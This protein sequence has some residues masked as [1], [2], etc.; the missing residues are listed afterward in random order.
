MNGNVGSGRLKIRPRLILSIVL[1]ALICF[2]L[3]GWYVMSTALGAAQ[4]QAETARALLWKDIL[5][6][7]ACFVV[8][9]ISVLLAANAVV[10]PIKL[11]TGYAGRLAV[12]DTDFKVETARRRDEVGDLS[13]SVRATQIT[14]KKV[15]LILGRASGDILKGNLSVRVDATKYPGDFGLIMDGSNKI[16]D[17]ICGLIRNMKT[18]AESVAAVSQQISAGAQSVAHGATSQSSSIEEISSTVAEVLERTR[19]NAESADQTR[20]LSEKVS[21]QAG[22]GSEKMKALFDALDAISRSS[23]TISSVIK[24]IEDIAFQTNILALNASVEAARAGVHGKGFSVVA[25][26]VKSLANKSAAAARET[27][28]LLGASIEKSKLGLRVG[29]EMEEALA[30]IVQSVSRSVVS[31]SE[32]AEDCALQVR[33]IEQVNIGLGQ[34]SQ[35]V[36]SNTATAEESAASSEEMAAQSAM[37]MEM[38]SNYKID[39]SRVVSDPSGFNENDY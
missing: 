31:I 32:I 35:V 3:A 12:G 6:I 30:D 1:P 2:S 24:L 5:V 22:L 38:V 34:I 39:V 28:E 25:E 10:K 29:Q 14:L 9:L 4:L 37:L 19:S 26:E 15:S 17:A 11:I 36:Q 33:T 8:L 27:N 20:R 23:S 21:A 16:D 7:G 13:R 18:S